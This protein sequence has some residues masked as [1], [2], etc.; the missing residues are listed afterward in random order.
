MLASTFKHNAR[1]SRRQCAHVM[2]TEGMKAA[3]Q[4]IGTEGVSATWLCNGSIHYFHGCVC[5]NNHQK[6]N[7]G[8]CDSKLL[9]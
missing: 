3:F 2:T 4:D 8:W 9:S 1:L 7:L 6:Y 5:F